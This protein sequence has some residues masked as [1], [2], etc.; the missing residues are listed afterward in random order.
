MNKLISNIIVVFIIYVICIYFSYIYDL[1]DKY[2]TYSNQ[3]TLLITKKYFETVHLLY[4]PK[5]NFN[6]IVCK[7]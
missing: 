4:T 7:L 5:H 1:Y 2:K 3:N 6:D